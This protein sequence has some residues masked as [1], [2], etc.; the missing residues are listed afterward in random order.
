MRKTSKTLLLER[1][2]CVLCEC[3]Q[4]Y[5][6]R[7]SSQTYQ[8]APQAAAVGA[9]AAAVRWPA[10]W[11]HCGPASNLVLIVRACQPVPLGL[12]SLRAYRFGKSLPIC[13][14]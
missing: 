14:Q 12:A 4:V 3:K 8:P 7:A 13:V 10:R 9:F 6:G 5:R 2:V 11:R 1:G